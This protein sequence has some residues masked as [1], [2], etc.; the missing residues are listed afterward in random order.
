MCVFLGTREESKA[1]RLYDPPSK[2]TIDR[3]DIVFLEARKWDWDNEE[4]Q[5][6]KKNVE[7]EDVEEFCETNAARDTET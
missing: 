6:E 2:R 4:G 7:E 3:W 1:Y 5:K